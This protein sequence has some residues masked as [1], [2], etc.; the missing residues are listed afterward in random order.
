MSREKLRFRMT[1]ICHD[2]PRRP[3]RMV[4]C[5][6]TGHHGKTFESD[7]IRNL[8]LLL[9]EPETVLWIFLTILSPRIFCVHFNLGSSCNLSP[10]VKSFKTGPWSWD[11]KWQCR[12]RFHN[13]QTRPSY[14]FTAVKLNMKS[15]SPR[16]DEHIF[17]QLFKGP[18]KKNIG[19]KAARQN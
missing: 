9:Y 14:Y 10:S 12:S 13:K 2:A 8:A 18:Q 17:F 6:F 7:K 19:S 1:P 3:L 4:C 5:I 11:Q 15:V 16:T